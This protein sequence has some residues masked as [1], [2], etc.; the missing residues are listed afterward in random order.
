MLNDRD[1]HLL[2][3]LERQLQQE[4]PAWVRQFK[5]PKAHRQARR[6]LRLGS[7]GAA[8]AS[9][10]PVSLAGHPRGS[11]D[12]RQRR[13]SSRVRPLPPVA[14]PWPTRGVGGIRPHRQQLLTN[15]AQHNRHRVTA[16]NPSTIINSNFLERKR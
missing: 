12:L 5:D 7:H 1:R 14:A 15:L 16:G 8:G 13:H 4:D 9:N 3:D 11:G 10:R 6:D 2:N